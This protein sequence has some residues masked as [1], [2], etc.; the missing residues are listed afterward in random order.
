MTH[1]GPAAR[2]GGDGGSPAATVLERIRTLVRR[3]GEKWSKA[4]RLVAATLLAA[5]GH[6]TADEIVARVRGYD[7]PCNLTAVYRTL[8]IFLDLGIVRRIGMDQ[9]PARYELTMGRRRHV[10]L[11]DAASQS[12]LDVACPA[13]EALLRQLLRSHGRRL[14]SACIDIHVLPSAG[15]RRRR[16]RL[17][18]REDD[19]EQLGPAG[20]PEL[21]VH[22]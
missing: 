22:P 14:A 1:P 15:R 11:I 2:P 3:D 13:L 19:M 4:R 17:S 6:L 9:G 5:R 10:H 7:T 12:V 8:A 18:D 20:H 21:R 16:G